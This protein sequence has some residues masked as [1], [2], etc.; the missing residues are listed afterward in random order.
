V[1]EQ[2]I[3]ISER[4]QLPLVIAQQSNLV[5]TTTMGTARSVRTG[6]FVCPTQIAPPMAILSHRCFT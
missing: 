5:A 4:Y 1:L 6:R 3:V 2:E